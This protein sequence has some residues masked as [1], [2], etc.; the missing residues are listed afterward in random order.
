MRKGII[1]V[2]SCLLILIAFNNAFAILVNLSKKDKA[3]ALQKGA[4]WKG[5]VTKYVKQHYAFGGKGVFEENGIL[6][7]KWSKLLLLA[8]LLAESGKKPTVQEQKSILT[9][10]DLQIDVHV[11]GNKMDFANGYKVYLI[12]G[13]RHIE[14]DKISADDVS[15]LSRRVG[16]SSTGF[17]QYYA[18]IRSFFAYDKINPKAK[19]KIV[20]V[21]DSKEVVFEINFADYK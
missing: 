4:E 18:T 19:T 11:F 5:S 16:V 10:I 17:P 1:A 13:G 9:D 7:T 20:L 6:R 12:Q 3:D 8:G 15:C 21:K 14:P 2:F